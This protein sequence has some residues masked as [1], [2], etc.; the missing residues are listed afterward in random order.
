MTKPDTSFGNRLWH[1]SSANPVLQQHIETAEEILFSDHAR[2]GELGWRLYTD[3]ERKRL[4]LL[5]RSLA[6]G[7]GFCIPKGRIA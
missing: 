1:I 7:S 5:A 2:F 3:E 6:Q 4:A